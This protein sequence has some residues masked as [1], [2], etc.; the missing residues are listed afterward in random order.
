MSKVL[1]MYPPG[2]LYQRGEDRCQGNIED[3]AATSMRACNDLGYAAAVLIRDGHEV[4]LR[5]YQTERVSEEEL[6]EDLKKFQPDM[7]MLS[8]TNST[9]YEDI[10][11][12][13]RM[14][15][16]TNASI[17]LKGAIFYAPEKEMLE[18]LDFTEIDYLIGG[19]V[20]FCIDKIVAYHFDGIGDVADIDNI[21]YK[22]KNGE[23]VCNRF[24][25]W[26]D[27][28]DDQPFPA[29]EYMNNELYLRPDTGRPMA[30][31]QTSRGCPS[32][33]IYCLSPDISGKRV[34]FRSPGNV[35][36]ELKECYDRYGIR[37]FF[38]R[39]DTFTIS[40]DWVE[41]LCGLI[42]ESHLYGKIAFTANSRV[43]PLNKR[44]LELMKDAG[45]FTVAFGFESGSEES[46]KKM[47]KGAT[48]EQN[49]QAMKWAKEVGIPVYG[50]Y[51]IGFP[52]ENESHLADTRRLI[53]ELNADF[54]EIHIALPYYGTML[55]DMCKEK[56]V[57]EDNVYGS[58][59]FHSATKGTQFLT[60]EQLIAFREKTMLRY[61]LR[62]SYIG[63][64]LAYSITKPYI[65]KNYIIYGCRMIKSLVFHKKKA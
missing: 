41:E 63:K 11:L 52:W 32:G 43:N 18:L 8:V 50:F 12:I 65:L 26:N 28:L 13:K 2:K 27:N 7:I 9:I 31:I 22:N 47:K 49:R 62:P 46:L 34:R 48:V 24:S 54:I 20:D 51:L 64:K 35:M 58:D 56:K 60:M 36:E 19:E 38:F 21:C 4:K 5:D 17:T 33:C 42:R 30:T 14:R 37:D 29:R 6:F 57:L 23:M 39:A 55:Y 59:Y 25:I 15:R 16:V 44:T 53:F 1:L 40:A 61:Y 10:A 3:S 45:C